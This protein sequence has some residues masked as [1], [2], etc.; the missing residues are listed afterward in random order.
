M[1][2]E[3]RLAGF[4]ELR[5]HPGVEADLDRRAHRI[6]EAAG[7]G[8]DVLPAQMGRTRARRLVAPRTAKAVSDNAR[9]NTLIRSLDAGR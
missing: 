3:W 2:I 1:K 9:H 6:A 7:A 4:R 5:Q 8:F